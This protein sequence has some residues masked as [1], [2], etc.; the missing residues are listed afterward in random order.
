MDSH[1]PPVS[2]VRSHSD[3]IRV[4][5]R[6]Q[7]SD[8]WARLEQVTFEYKRAD[9][10]WQTQQREIYHRGHGAAVLLY[11]LSLRTIVLIRQFRFPA[12][13]IGEDGFLVEV[14]A[15]IIESASPHDTVRKETE[16][17]TGFLI[18][19]PQFLF[20]A[21]ATPG[22]VTEQLHYFSASYE[23]G[24]RSGSGGGLVEEGEDIEVLEVDLNQ[25]VDWIREGK[26]IDAKTIILIQYAQLSVFVN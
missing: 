16:E 4:T 3:R 9:G 15:G 26:I 17:E 12:W 21:F 18:G 22:S 11:N 10:S 13:D 24:H 2:Q 5:Q 19:E 6:T 8:H 23:P 7:R 20:K 14:P 25:A 1:K